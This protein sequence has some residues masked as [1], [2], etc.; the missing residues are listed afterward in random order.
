M[1]H[2]TTTILGTA[3]RLASWALSVSLAAGCT[4]AI[5]PAGRGRG[6]SDAGTSQDAGSPVGPDISDAGTGDASP[7]PPTSDA[8]G[9]YATTCTIPPGTPVWSIPAYGNTPGVGDFYQ[10]KFGAEGY[11]GDGSTR[12]DGY[13]AVVTWPGQPALTNDNDVV[14]SWP[15]LDLEGGWFIQHGYFASTVPCSGTL[16]VFVFSP[17]AADGSYDVAY[18]QTLDVSTACGSGEPV[19]FKAE[20]QGTLWVFYYRPVSQPTFTELGRYDFGTEVRGVNPIQAITE[21]YDYDNKANQTAPVSLTQILGK[22]DGQWRPVERL[23]YSIDTT[24]SWLQV[25][26]KPEVVGITTSLF[27]PR[28]Y[29]DGDTLFSN[30]DPCFGTALSCDPT[31]AI[32][33][34]L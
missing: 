19:Q 31:T 17:P 28:C 4:A 27:G 7:P 15:G 32:C 12:I 3:H 14:T 20:R 13:S 5:P 23:A 1:P 21:L 22:V 25:Q 8:C 16:W 9:P 2:R 24:N 11:I 34:T 26:P 18:E 30:T 10:P 29:N 33:T 6:S